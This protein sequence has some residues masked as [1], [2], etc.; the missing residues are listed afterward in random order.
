MRL[1]LVWLGAFVRAFVR[2][3][4]ALVEEL[5]DR[6]GERADDLTAG[7]AVRRGDPIPDDLVER[8]LR[9]AERARLRRR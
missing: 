9:R 8:R 1:R 4:D 6:I 3:I 7:E 2:E 5:V